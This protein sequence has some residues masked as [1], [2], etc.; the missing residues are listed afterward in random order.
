[1][2]ISNVVANIDGEVFFTTSWSNNDSYSG[3]VCRLS[4]VQTSHPI[5]TCL[6]NAQLY[7]STNSPLSLNDASVY[8]FTTVFNEGANQVPATIDTKTL[9]F[10]W[11]DRGVVGAANDSL[12]S[13]DATGIFWIGRDDHLYKVNGRD[14]RILDVD[15]SSGGNRYYAFNRF[16]PTIVRAWQNGSALTAPLIVSGWNVNTGEDFHLRW[17]WNEPSGHVGPCTQPVTTDQSEMTYIAALPYVYAINMDGTTR[18]QV[19]IATSDEMQKFQ[20]VSICLALNTN[21]NLIYVT[22]SSISLGQT[23]QS[24]TLFIAPIQIATGTILKRINIDVSPESTVD[25]NCPIL[26]G[27]DLLYLSWMEKHSS[28]VVSLKIMG[29]P[30][31]TT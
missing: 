10:V 19:E 13:S 27:D 23:E 31:L 12:Y 2:G 21:T 25:V 11:I 18:W 30:Q 1:M 15:I 22:I 9:E 20:L 29:L 4:D 3:K 28:D 24:S 26:I 8:L 7:A 5:A 17:Q 14:S 16:Q 6:E